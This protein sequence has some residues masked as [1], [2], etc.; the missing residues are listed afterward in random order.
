MASTMGKGK[1]GK[2]RELNR[3]RVVHVQIPLT[4]YVGLKFSASTSTLVLD[5]ITGINVQTIL[6]STTGGYRKMEYRL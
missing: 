4:S 3:D 2:E 1:L 6:G 5:R